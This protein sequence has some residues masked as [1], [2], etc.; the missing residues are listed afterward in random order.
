MNATQRLSL[1]TCAMTFVLIVVGVIVRATGSGLG[2]PDWPLCHG[3]AVPPLQHHSLIEFSH[4]FTA[5]IVGFLVIG[6]A[7]LVW[8]NY[9]QIPVIA[10]AAVITVPLVG[11]QGLLGALTVVRELPPEIVATHL[12]TAMLVLSFELFVFFGMLLAETAVRGGAVP[13]RNTRAGGIALA[14]LAW[15]AVL[16]WVG[17]YMAESGASTACTSWPACNGANIFPGNDSQEITH[18]LHRYL[19]GAF[20]FVLAAFILAVKRTTRESWKRAVV[21]VTGAL[22]AAQVMVGALNVWFTFPDAL[23]VLHTAIATSLWIVLASTAILYYYRP[24][25]SRRAGVPTRAEVPA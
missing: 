17:A 8:R 9:R 3:G 22:Y 4:R 19:A 16:M 6:V 15:L 18:M 2:C 5:T 21:A 14:A 23:S 20:L 12:I 11:V 25:A 13:V 24:V 1:I 10:W 7:I